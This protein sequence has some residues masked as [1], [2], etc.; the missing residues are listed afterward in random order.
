[1]WGF[2]ESYPQTKHT[3]SSG[4]VC[5]RTPRPRALWIVPRGPGTPAAAI[6]GML[7]GCR[8]GGPRP[9]R[10]G[11]GSGWMDFRGLG[12]R[13]RFPKLR[14]RDAEFP[15]MDGVLV[16][17]GSHRQPWE[18]AWGPVG[19]LVSGF[20]LASHEN[21]RAAIFP[22]HG[23]RG[24]RQGWRLVCLFVFLGAAG[25]A[26]GGWCR[27]GLR[28]CPGLSGD[29]AFCRSQRTAGSPVGGNSGRGGPAGHN[30]TTYN[31][32]RPARYRWTWNPHAHHTPEKTFSG[33]LRCALGR[34][35]ARR[36][37]H[38]LRPPS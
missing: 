15:A 32:A 35:A 21:L 8:G 24:L 17:G 4:F 27:W 9:G 12:L 36:P 11:S 5:P 34:S 14:G 38:R 10:S 33:A 7:R 26:G 1:M 6:A 30:R 20:R 13:L 2:Q 28:L 37:N 3:L 29:L 31:Q 22:R 18:A 16:S 25:A 19:V 23:R